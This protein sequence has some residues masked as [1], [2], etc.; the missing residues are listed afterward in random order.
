M[1]LKND[2][3]LLPLPKDLGR[4]AVIGPHTDSVRNLFS[5]YTA[6]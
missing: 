1:L 3:G 5:G 4:V 2:R 6:P